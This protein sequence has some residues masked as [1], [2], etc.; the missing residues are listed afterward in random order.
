M[1]HLRSTFSPDSPIGY[2]DLFEQLQTAPLLVLD[3]LGS[4]N[5]TPWAEDKLYQIIAQRHEARLPTVITSAFSLEELEEAKPRI[6]SRLVDTMVVNWQPIS[7]P[8][9]RDQRREGSMPTS[10]TPQ[11]HGR[12]PAPPRH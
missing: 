3:D 9:Y 5:S 8:N 10:P 2:D 6:A 1:D 12:R 11:Q 7:A 4:E